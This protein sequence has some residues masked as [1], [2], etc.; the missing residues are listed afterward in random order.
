LALLFDADWAVFGVMIGAIPGLTGA[1][2]IAFTPPLTYTMSDPAE[3][4]TPLVSIDVGAISGGI[5][6]TISPLG[7]AR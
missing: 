1:M 4:M 3:A 2:L 5:S 6:A 7:G